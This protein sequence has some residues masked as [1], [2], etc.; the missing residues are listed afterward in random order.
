[1]WSVDRVPVSVEC[2][3][4]LVIHVQDNGVGMTQE[5]LDQLFHVDFYD[6][7]GRYG[8][9]YVANSAVALE[10]VVLAESDGPGQ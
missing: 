6:D 9:H 10:G 5:H 7:E 2:A 4:S 1:M 8:L 3:I